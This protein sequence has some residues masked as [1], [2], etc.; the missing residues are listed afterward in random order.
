MKN[1]KKM[2]NQDYGKTKENTVFKIAHGIDV[3]VVRIKTKSEGN[4]VTAM[5]K[6]CK[7]CIAFLK[8]IGIRKVYY[9]IDK[10]NMDYVCEYI[11]Q[12]QSDH[13]SHFDKQNQQA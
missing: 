7:N 11:E 3:Y 9:S 6:P 8:S 4:Y 10:K 1:Q 2:I 13:C 12:L 5:S